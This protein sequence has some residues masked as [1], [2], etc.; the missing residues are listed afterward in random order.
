M[1]GLLILFGSLL[2]YD[3]DAQ[4]ADHVFLKYHDFFPFPILLALMLNEAQPSLEKKYPD[5]DIYLPHFMSWVIVVSIF[6]V[7]LTEGGVINNMIESLWGNVSH[8]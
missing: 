7:L 2:R 5:A 1:L 4:H 3:V 8:S 6:Y